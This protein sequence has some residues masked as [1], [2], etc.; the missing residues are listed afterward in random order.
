MQKD[1]PYIFEVLKRGSEEAEKIAAQTL[2]E[3]R[4]SMKINYF[5]DTA[6]IKEQAEKFK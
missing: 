6:L 1:I 2:K 4:D 3:V 5:A